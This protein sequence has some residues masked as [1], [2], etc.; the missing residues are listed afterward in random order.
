[1]DGVATPLLTVEQVVYL[2]ARHPLRP[3]TLEPRDRT[4]AAGKISEARRVILMGHMADAA[5][6]LVI[7]ARRPTSKTIPHIETCKAD[8]T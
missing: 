3:Q 7:V 1:M 5:R 6:R 2:D 8:K 4:V